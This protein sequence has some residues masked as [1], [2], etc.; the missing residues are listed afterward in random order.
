M[1]NQEYNI[2]DNY[3]F[4]L[5]FFLSFLSIGNDFYFVL[6]EMSNHEFVKKRITYFD[7]LMN[8]LKNIL[9][10]KV[11]KVKNGYVINENKQKNK[12]IKNELKKN[13][14]NEI[15]NKDI[16]TEK[17]KLDNKIIEE[18]NDENDEYIDN[19]NKLKVNYKNNIKKNIKKKSN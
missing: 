11:K 17:I 13:N 19:L 6:Q 5:F 3:A 2:I 16:K 7:D 18:F 10:N 8:I 1:D 14:K 15:L 12:L 4:Y 9:S